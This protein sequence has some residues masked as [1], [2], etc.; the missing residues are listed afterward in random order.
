[1]AAAGKFGDSSVD[2]YAIAA[3]ATDVYTGSVDVINVHTDCPRGMRT[4]GVDCRAW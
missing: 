3:E 4:I 2:L 1:M